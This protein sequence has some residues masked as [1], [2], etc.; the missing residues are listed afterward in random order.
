MKP[1]RKEENEKEKEKKTNELVGNAKA[2]RKA[3]EVMI[4]NVM[5]NIFFLPIRSPMTPK[6]I[7]PQIAPA[8]NMFNLYDIME[9]RLEDCSNV[10]F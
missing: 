10:L 1:V 4:T 2:L 6:K 8:T 3:M 9:K 5:T 7:C